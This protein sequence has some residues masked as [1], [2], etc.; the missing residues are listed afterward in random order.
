MYNIT[1]NIDP[2]QRSESVGLQEM[3]AM[4]ST[5]T[6]AQ[7]RR[8]NNGYLLRCPA[9]DDKNPSLS[10]S[11]SSDGKIL[12]HCHAKCTCKDICAALNIQEASLFPEK[13]NHKELIHLAPQKVAQYGY[14]D[15]NNNVTCW[16]N[17]WVPGFN[18]KDKSFTWH[19]LGENGKEIN[20]RDGCR[21]V[22]YNLPHVLNSITEGKQ[23][24]LVEGEKDVATLLQKEL[25]ATTAPE[26]ATWEDE[27]TETLKDADVV[28]LY[29]MDKT[30]FARRDTLCEKLSGKVK[31]FRVID[32]PG[33]KYRNKHGDD[34]TDWLQQGHTIEELLALVEKAADY[35]PA[36]MS[37]TV[38]KGKLI[39]I[40]LENL[41]CREL[42]PRS[43]ILSPFLVSQGLVMLYAKRG[44]GKTH[45]ALGIAH[46]VASGG[47]FLKWHAPEPKRVLYIDGEMPAYSLQERLRKIVSDES[48]KAKQDFLQFITPD[49]QD[50]II[51]DLSTKEGRLA[52]EPFVVDCD[53][54]IIDNISSLFRSSAENEAESWQPVQEWA[55]DLR[56]REK[57]ILFVHHAGK[58]G[59]QRG[60]SKREDQLDAVIILKQPDD[61]Q[62]EQGACFNIHFEKA[63]H[64]CGADAAAFKVKLAENDD[65]SCKWE[66]SH[67]D[68]D[69]EIMEIA[70]LR[71]EG[72]TI[73]EICGKTDLTKSQVETLIKKARGLGLIPK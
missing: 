2:Q 66:M 62:P 56:R 48:Q 67:V 61:Y 63:R 26:S 53:L 10:V 11:E 70:T 52:I 65:G 42:P 15:E 68:V 14:L 64:F 9:H 71:N 58:S 59:Q 19:R 1:R 44:V 13:S 24:F 47:S 41:L 30:G 33:L 27:F 16:K 25:V 72:A 54:V 32:L 31:R 28:L 50:D 43:M 17:R 69:E 23:I 46:A 7:P 3:L 73:V 38:S 37:N 12:L 34:V 35:D 8:S 36:T 4:I 49:L 51:P 57:S 55:L 22:L 5:K 45:I 20:N 39:A 6:G 40:S 29:D 18:G 21:K 60:T